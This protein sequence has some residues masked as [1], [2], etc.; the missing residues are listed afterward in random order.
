MINHSIRRALGEQTAA[1]VRLKSGKTIAARIVRR[2]LGERRPLGLVPYLVRLGDGRRVKLMSGRWWARQAVAEI[3]AT[4]AA[5]SHLAC[6]PRLLWRDDDN[7][8]VEFV[9]GE[10]PNVDD[11]NF[12]DTLGSTLAAIHGIDVGSVARDEVVAHAERT[13]ARLVDAQ[14]AGHEAVGTATRWLVKNLPAALRTSWAYADLKESNFCWSADGRLVAFDLGS[15]RRASI[16]DEYL[17][18]GKLSGEPLLKRLKHPGR[19]R[20]SYRASPGG[21]PELFDA[22]A[23]LEPLSAVRLASEVLD[24]RDALPHLFWRQRAS[25][26]AAASERLGQMFSLIRRAE[27]S[28]R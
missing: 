15:F 2:A 26:L 14:V 4:Y 18:G 8:I 28:A 17:A 3:A 19:L 13:L 9:A 27:A 7:L 6:V 11:A 21:Y 5:V 25:Y 16:T 10:T 22:F 12:A 20:D 23:W 1:V 24:R